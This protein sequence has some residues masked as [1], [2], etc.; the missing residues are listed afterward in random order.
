[1]LEVNAAY[2]EAKFSTVVGVQESPTKVE[3]SRTLWFA[4]CKTT[5]IHGSLAG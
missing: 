1:M 3:G 2:H 5:E 4:S